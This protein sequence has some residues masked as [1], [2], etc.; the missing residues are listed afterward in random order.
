MLIWFTWFNL[1]FLKIIFFSHEQP[2][3]KHQYSTATHSWNDNFTQ[4][5]RKSLLIFRNITKWISNYEKWG[6]QDRNFMEFVKD[7]QT[8]LFSKLSWSMKVM[9][10]SFSL[11]KP[12]Q[13]KKLSNYCF[14]YQN[15]NKHVIMKNF[16]KE[17][18]TKKIMNC[19][20]Q[21]FYLLQALFIKGHLHNE[22]KK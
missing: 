8:F 9:M 22:T 14:F 2:F 3:T 13:E 4:D 21:A 10:V 1:I 16:D 20:F 11:E 6:T 12:I 5:S 19:C 17:K 7:L 15:N 18:T